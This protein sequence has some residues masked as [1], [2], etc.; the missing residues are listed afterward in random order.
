MAG[1]RPSNTCGGSTTWS[2]TL[3][4][5]MSSMSKLDL[6]PLRA[7]PRRARQLTDASLRTVPREPAPRIGLAIRWGPRPGLAGG[8]PP[9]PLAAAWPRDPV[10]AVSLTVE[11]CSPDD[12]TRLPMA[13][14]RSS[15]DAVEAV[16][17][18][19]DRLSDGEPESA[20]R[21]A[22]FSDNPQ[23]GARGQRTQQRILDAALQVFG[24]RG[25]PPQRHRPHHRGGGLL[26]GVVLPVLLQQG[27]RLPPPRGPGRPPAQ[28]LDRGARASSPPTSRAGSRCG[29]GSAATPTSTTATSRCSAPS[30]PR[31]RATRP[32]APGRP[33]PPSATRR[34]SVRSWPP[35]RSR[36]ASSTRSS[37]SC[38][39]ASPAPRT[40]WPRPAARPH[41]TPTPDERVD[42]ALTDVMHRSLFGLVA[43]VNVHP[44]AEHRPPTLRLRPGPARRASPART[45][46]PS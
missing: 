24:E 43:D 13:P 17:A 46:P 8:E 18:V 16:T 40:T 10:A 31:P 21:R 23:V 22:P 2:S 25:L 42:D 37:R 5:T 32:S 33:A 27:R 29:P 35:P 11:S 15:S 9:P 39:S 38:S 14:P 20:I 36:P 26:A 28:R 30:R 7:P 12:V 34:G 19:D 45:P 4:S 3:T 1:S 44:P 41:R 6:R